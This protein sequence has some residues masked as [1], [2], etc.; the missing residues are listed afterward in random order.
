MAGATDAKVLDAQ[1]GLESAFH[2]LAQGLGGLN[3][4]HDVGYMDMGMICSADMLVL[5]D[6]IVGMARRFIR[7]VE[8]N[9]ET[10]A[11]DVISQVGPGG[12]YLEEDHTYNHFRQQLWRPSLLTRHGRED[13]QEAG[14]KDLAQK[15]REKVLDILNTHQASPLPDDVLSTIARLRENGADEL[16]R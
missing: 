16:G 4:I 15:I 9:S 1:A 10:L 2:I 14:G 12:H 13:W 8:V 3:L 6:E 7:G 11:R 5:G